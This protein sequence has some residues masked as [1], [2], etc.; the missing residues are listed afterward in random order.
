IEYSEISK[1]MAE[2]TDENGEL[3][4]GESNIMAHLYNINAL[5]KISQTDLPYHSAHKKANYLKED[6]TMFIATEPNAYKYE[7]FIFDGFS[8]F[9]NMSVLRVR[10]DENFAPIKNK[11]GNDSPS[12][13]IELYNKFWEKEENK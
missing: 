6:G 12:T 8:F 7:A 10:R 1:E 9:D 2:A 13:A 4:Y 3:L 11:E 5:D